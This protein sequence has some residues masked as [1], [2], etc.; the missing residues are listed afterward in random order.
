MFEFFI[1]LF[2]IIL[3]LCFAYTVGAIAEEFG[4]SKS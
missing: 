2:G 1:V 3:I 4:I